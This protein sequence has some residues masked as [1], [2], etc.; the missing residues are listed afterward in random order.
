ME[1]SRPFYLLVVGAFVVLTLATSP[2]NGE[3][4]EEYWKRRSEEAQKF[5]DAA[6]VQD[7][8]IVTDSLNA[9]VHK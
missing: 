9:A 7:P 8:F 6:Y 4:D 2:I 5:V 1:H 3:T